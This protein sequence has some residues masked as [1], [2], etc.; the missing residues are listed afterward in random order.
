MTLKHQLLL[1]DLQSSQ[2]SWLAIENTVRGSEGGNTR[3]KRMQETKT[4]S[5]N[6]TPGVGFRRVSRNHINVIMLE[7]NLTSVRKCHFL[8]VVETIKQNSRSSL[9]DGGLVEKRYPNTN[10]MMIYK[11]CFFIITTV[12]DVSWAVVELPITLWRGFLHSY[13]HSERKKW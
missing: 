11:V 9:Q 12:C 1:T 10:L 3:Q 2:K 8:V 4:L 7:P 6:Q 5:N 13:K